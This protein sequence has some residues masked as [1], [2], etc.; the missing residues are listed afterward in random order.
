M[1]EHL[2]DYGI[3]HRD[4]SPPSITQE[5]SENLKSLWMTQRSCG[6]C[7]WG[8]RRRQGKAGGRAGSAAAGCVKYAFPFLSLGEQSVGRRSVGGPR[9]HRCSE[10]ERG[11]G[12]KR[13][14]ALS[15]LQAGAYRFSL[16]ENLFQWQR[17]R[18]S[19]EGQVESYLLSYSTCYIFHDLLT[20]RASR[21]SK[22]LNS[23]TGRRCSPHC[24]Q[25]QAY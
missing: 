16:V 10:R 24:G 4:S 15:G 1:G 19:D 3:L 8:R 11:P 18:I 13:A 22:F 17:L 12:G 9:L 21:D 25:S 23:Y 6:W 20:G 2:I 7:W 5:L 14:G